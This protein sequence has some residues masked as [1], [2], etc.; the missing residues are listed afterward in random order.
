MMS[1]IHVE[2]SILSMGKNKREIYYLDL[3]DST[4]V[5]NLTTE[6]LLQILKECPLSK[7]VSQDVSS[8]YE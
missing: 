4:E 7:F 3:P 6:E 5:A 8:I 1:A 2:K